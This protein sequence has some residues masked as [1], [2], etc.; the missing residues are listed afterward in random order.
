MVRHR[1]GGR[2]LHPRG[3][4][5]ADLRRRERRLSHAEA[6]LA[7]RPRRSTSWACGPRAR[8]AA[9]EPRSSWQPRTSSASAS[10]EFLQVKTLGPSQP[11][12]ALRANASLLRDVRLPAARG[13]DRDL[14]RGEPV[15]DHGQVPALMPLTVGTAGHID[16]GKTWLVRALTG[17]DT[18]RLPEEQARGISIELGYAQLELPS[19][20]RLSLVDVPGHERFVRT[21]VAGRD[22]DRPLPARDRR[23]RGRAAAD[24]RAPRDP[25]PARRRPGR[26]RGDEGGRRRR[27]DARARARRGAGARSR[28]G[29][30]RRERQDRRRARRTARG[31]RAVRGLGRARAAGR[32]GEALHR[33]R[34][35][36]H[37]RG[38]RRHRDALVG[39][40]R[41]G[42][43]AAGRAFGPPHARPKRPGARSRGRPGR[44]GPAR[45]GEPPRGRALTAA[46][47]RRPRRAGPL[48]GQLAARHRAPGARAGPGRGDGSPRDERR[49]GTTRARRPLRT[50]AAARHRWSRR[51]ATGSC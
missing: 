35:Q 21:M 30:R 22:R 19:G 20:Q 8:D 15:P 42:R 10:V 12:Q 16:H 23:G 2:P 37:G 46:A 3:R 24:A 14:G 7:V 38:D 17:K 49:A 18:D 39:L 51:A 5:A 28:G 47:R 11:E 27:G 9:R 25:A 6:P 29:G 44:S 33:P 4:R 40:D 45:C 32:G 13:D 31:A 48:P 34:V 36:P 26:R 43:R 41:C 1:G 50:A